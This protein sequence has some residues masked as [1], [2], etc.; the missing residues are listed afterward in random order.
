[1]LFRSLPPDLAEARER[2]AAALNDDLNTSAALAVLFE[3]AKPLRALAN[4]LA[5]GDQEAQLEVRQD[6]LIARAR[7]L[8]ELAGVLGLKGE[9]AN[10]TADEDTRIQS[11]IEAR[12]AAKAAKDFAEADRIR[13][14]LQAEGI[15][16]IDKPGGITQWI[17]S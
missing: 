17:R 4:R 16:L 14:A 9:Q 2:F 10:A 1:M 13:A 5:R 8:S 7:L 6:A 15:E 12:T 3:L 11:Q